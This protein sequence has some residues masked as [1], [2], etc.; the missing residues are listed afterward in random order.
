MKN[1]K[2][3]SNCDIFFESNNSDINSNVKTTN[4]KMGISK[5]SYSIKTDKEAKQM[6]REKGKYVIFD[7]KSL[8]CFDQSLKKY[9]TKLLRDEIRKLCG[10][11]SNVNNVLVV[12]VGNKSMVADCL[13][14]KVVENIFCTRQFPKSLLDER[15]VDVSAYSL[16]VF[17]KTGIESA[18]VVQKLCSIVNPSLVIVVDTYTTSVL[19]R[20]NKSVQISSCGLS[21]GSGVDNARKYINKQFLNVPVFSI[22]VPLLIQEQ[23]LLNKNKGEYVFLDREIEKYLQFYSYVI[24]NAINTAFHKNVSINEIQDLRY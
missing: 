12:G 7:A 2:K 1:S 16:G 10:K 13:G 21:P 8:N 22:G 18:E 14:D 4:L 15:F 3:Q 23:T 20:L 19:G 11:N 9:L 24:S 5:I 17:G 6:G